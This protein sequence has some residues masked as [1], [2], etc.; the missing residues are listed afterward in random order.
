MDA[1]MTALLI[2]IISSLIATGLFITLGEIIRKIILPWFSD[3][4]YRGVR[5]D[6]KW[7]MTSCNGVPIHEQRGLSELNINQKA[8]KLSG[9]YYHTD[10][11]GDRTDYIVT[12]RIRDGFVMIYAVPK[13]NRVIDAFTMLFEIKYIKSLL[14]LSGDASMVDNDHKVI[15][16][17]S[18]IYQLK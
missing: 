5:L 1:N 16:M 3:A 13:S 18:I 11:S 4:I 9:D 6:G 17:T 8:D 10:Q 12:G 2:G 7:I 14:H 15:T